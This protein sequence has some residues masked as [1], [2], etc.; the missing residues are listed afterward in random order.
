MHKNPIKLN[1]VGIDK[2]CVNFIMVI[3]K[4]FI[5]IFI[6]FIPLDWLNKIRS[7]GA[8]KKMNLAAIKSMEN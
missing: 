8:T 7:F 5:I 3:F 4:N 2:F 1:F 6:Q